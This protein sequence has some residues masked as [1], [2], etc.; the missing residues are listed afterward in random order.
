M[1][2]PKK[3]IKKPWKT[4]KERCYLKKKQTKRPA[5]IKEQFL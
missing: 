2:I 5:M 3:K 4:D 1:I